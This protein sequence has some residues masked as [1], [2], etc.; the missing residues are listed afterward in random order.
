MK[1]KTDA[2]AALERLIEVCRAHLSTDAAAR[3]LLRVNGLSDESVWDR[4]R[5]GATGKGVLE[6]LDAAGRSALVE[7]GYHRAFGTSALSTGLRCG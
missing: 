3:E 1:T 4:Y 5:L 7:M 2:T 6:G